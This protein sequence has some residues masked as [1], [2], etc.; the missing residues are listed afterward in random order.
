MIISLKELAASAEGRICFDYT[1]DLSGEEV[2]FEYPFEEP[3]RVSGQVSDDAG[4]IRLTAQVAA[5]VHTRCA[6]CNCPVVYDKAVD[7]DFALVSAF[8]GSEERDDVIAVSSDEVDLDAI[9]VPELILD[10]EMA[11]LCDENCKGLCPKCGKNLN[12][13]PCG[14]AE[15]PVDPRLEALKQLLPRD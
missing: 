1:I 13:G 15:K 2:N 4:M 5:A 6:R 10:M 3:V 7:V 8:A 12:E 9:V 11:V 14:C